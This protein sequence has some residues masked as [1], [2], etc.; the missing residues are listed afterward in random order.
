MV[1]P[2]LADTI[3]RASR[4]PRRKLGWDDR[5][6]G[7][8]RLGMAQGVATPRYAMGIAA[9]LEVLRRSGEAGADA[10]L[11]RACWP[12]DV[13]QAEADSVLATVAQGRGSLERWLEGGFPAFAS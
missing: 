2:W 5:L 10:D 8:L 7:L 1:N 3:E 13:P 9:G 12:A 4:D 6:V 11:L